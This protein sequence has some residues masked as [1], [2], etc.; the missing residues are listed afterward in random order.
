MDSKNIIQS[1]LNLSPAERLFIID[2]ISKSLSEPDK[3]IDEYWK[4]EVEKR[5]D[6]FIKGKVKRIPYEEIR[7]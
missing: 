7:K 5:Y 6:A 2:A 3:D 4:D 1:A